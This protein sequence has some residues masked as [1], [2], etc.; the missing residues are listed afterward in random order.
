MHLVC[1]Q[2]EALIIIIIIGGKCFWCLDAFGDICEM[3]SAFHV[4]IP[5]LYRPQESRDNLN[6]HL[7]TLSGHMIAKF[8]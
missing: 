4:M 7:C 8:D 5:T 6:E 3:K 1:E 2:N